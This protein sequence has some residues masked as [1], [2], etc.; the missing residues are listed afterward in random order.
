MEFWTTEWKPTNTD[1]LGDPSLAALALIHL[2]VGKDAHSFSEAKN[3]TP[4]IVKLCRA[5]QLSMLVQAHTVMTDHDMSAMQALDVVETFVQEKHLNT[6]ST[7]SSLKH[8]AAKLAYGTP[9]L[10]RIVWPQ[11]KSQDWTEM[12]LDG[13][14]LSIGDL[15]NMLVAMEQKVTQIW[16]TK[17]LLGV[18]VDLEWGVLADALTNSEL[19]YSCL[20]NP[21]FKEKEGL[22][23]NAFLTTDTLKDKFI[24]ETRE[25]PI[26]DTFKACQWLQSVAELEMLLLL[27]TEMKSGAPIRLAELTCTLARNTATR[28]RN[29]MGVGS[30]LA[31]V[32]QYSKTSSNEG[33]DRLIPHGLSAFESDL[34][35][36]L[37]VL[38]R[39]F[40]KARTLRSF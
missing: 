5:I 39:P 8:Y 4:D 24:K 3:V 16:E 33:V 27:G 22:L 11:R 26:I 29:L 6:F 37:H 36:K 12:I 35:L 18:K 31:I 17:V 13:N 2:Q 25:G 30:H 10:P 9:S 21:A 40:A 7:L 32:R 20:D 15:R 19:G 34:I 14:P 28:H 23:A 1:V 38:V